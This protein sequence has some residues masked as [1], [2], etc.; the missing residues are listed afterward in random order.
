MK[1]SPIFLFVVLLLAGPGSIA[2]SMGKH[3]GA[4]L[5]GRPLNIS[6][7]AILDSQED[8]ASLCLEADVFYADVRQ[9][10]S[11]VK[12]AAEK[13]LVSGRD[14]VIRISSSA[15][16][17]EP[18]VTIYLRAGCQQKTEKRYVVLADFVSEAARPSAISQVPGSISV[19]FPPGNDPGRCLAVTW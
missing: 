17:D 6:V 13:T 14:A 10:K 2:M 7:E 16:V 4:A 18:V 8:L 3:R 1:K 12:V 19:G 15:L 9:D 11:R 5:I